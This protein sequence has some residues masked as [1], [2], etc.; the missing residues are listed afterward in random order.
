MFLTSKLNIGILFQC[1]WDLDFLMND[2]MK[3]SLWTAKIIERA[4]QE[5]Q[6]SGLVRSLTYTNQ[7][8]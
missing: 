6:W 2:Q 4:N 3:L 8:L 1:F 7:C 5:I